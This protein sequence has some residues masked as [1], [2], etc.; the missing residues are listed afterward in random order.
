V[1]AQAGRERRL[2]AR[3]RPPGTA[4]RACAGLR[5][6]SGG[7]SAGSAAATPAASGKPPVAH[8]TTR[9]APP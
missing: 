8:R 3:P 7:A 2:P 9:Q 6:T 5:G 1:P 4:A